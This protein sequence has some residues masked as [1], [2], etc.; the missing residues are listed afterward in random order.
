MQVWNVHEVDVLFNL[1]K[2]GNSDSC[3]DMNEL[4]EKILGLMKPVT[5]R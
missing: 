3:Y 2:E 1:L 4:R 5:K